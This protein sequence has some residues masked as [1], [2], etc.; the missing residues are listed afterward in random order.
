MQ[1][2]L[3]GSTFSPLLPDVLFT[4]ASPKLKIAGIGTCIAEWLLDTARHMGHGADHYLVRFAGEALPRADWSAY[5]LVLVHITLRRATGVIDNDRGDGRNDLFH[6]DHL[7]DQQYKDALAAVSAQIGRII[8]STNAA[9][10]AAAPVFYLSFI[11]PPAAY[12]GI[13]LNNRRKSLHHFVRSLNDGMAAMLEGLPNAHFI[14]MND[15]V[16]YYGDGVAS[17]AYELFLSHAGIT[18][19]PGGHRLRASIVKRLMHAMSILRSEAPVKLIVTDLDNTLWKGVAAEMEEIDVHG[20]TEGWPL[21]YVE[22]LLEFKRRGGLLAIS[23]KNDHAATLKRFKEIWGSR[24]KI[25]DFCSVKINW[26]PKSNAIREI[27]AET[28][29][30]PGSVLFIDDNP[31]EIEEVTRAFPEVRTLTGNPAVWRN[32]IF[33]AP[34]T[35]AA[36]ISDESSARTEMIQAK[37]QRDKLAGEMDHDSYLRSLDLSIRFDEIAS[38]EH[39]KFARALELINKTNQFNSTGIRWSVGDFDAY[40]SQGG[41]LI[42]ASVTDKFSDNGLVALA[43]VREREVTQ[44]VMSCRV[45]GLGVEQALMHSVQSAT[46]GV[47]LTLLFIETDKNKSC[48][49]FLEQSPFSSG[50]GGTYFLSEPIPHP[51]WIG[52]LHSAHGS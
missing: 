31:R 50:E 23:S 19:S 52:A 43:A 13:L 33:Y 1:D 9:V 7:T 2:E 28:N 27:L 4:S 26:K 34:Q 37:Q 49:V 29:L 11:E 47:P 17:D 41:R 8:E 14:E 22:A 6:T 18:G 40:L 48:R 38:I 10:G 36:R 15:L 25:E 46:Q 5:D 24:L 45:F 30:L 20:L 12:Q 21:G 3:L 51:N 32:V 44:M 39:P 42:G 35:Q 16:R